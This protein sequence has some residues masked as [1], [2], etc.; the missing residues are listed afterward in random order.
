MVFWRNTIR[1][2]CVLLHLLNCSMLQKTLCQNFE[3]IQA[4][5][6]VRLREDFVRNGFFF[7]NGKI[8]TAQYDRFLGWTIRFSFPWF[9]NNK[10]KVYWLWLYDWSRKCIQMSGPLQNR[11][12]SPLKDSALNSLSLAMI[13]AKHC[14]KKSYWYIVSVSDLSPKISTLGLTLWVSGPRGIFAE[15]W[16]PCHHQLIGDLDPAAF[17][18]RIDDPV[19]TN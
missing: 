19:I 12:M 11:T 10:I 14:V 2:L 5:F 15:I 16:W 3:A 4:W 9:Q 6:P 7:C 1:L 18:R 8:W 13:N 17:S